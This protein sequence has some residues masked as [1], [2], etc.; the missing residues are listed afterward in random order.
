MGRK[1]LK[2][3]SPGESSPVPEELHVRQKWSGLDSPTTP[4]HCLTTTGE[5]CGLGSKA[6]TS[7]EGT[8]PGICQPSHRWMASSFL[9]G[10]PSSMLG[11]YRLPLCH[12]DP[13]LLSGAAL[14][15]SSR[16]LYM[17]WTTTDEQPMWLIVLLPTL[18]S[19][20]SLLSIIIFWFFKSAYFSAADSLDFVQNPSGLHWEF[21]NWGIP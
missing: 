4:D 20:S 19:K 2:L 13:R 15:D 7:Y 16:S 11:S 17:R 5:E 12:M 14:Q 3:E 9:K 6:V 18:Y 8:A 10:D 1:S 21:S